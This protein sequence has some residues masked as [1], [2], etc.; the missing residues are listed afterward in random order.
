M[1]FLILQQTGIVI[2]S[3]HVTDVVF[4]VQVW[5]PGFVHLMPLPQDIQ[6]LMFSQW[7]FIICGNY[8]ATNDWQ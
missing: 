2:D 8:S 4:G 6:P 3:Y 1:F 7:Q 5:K